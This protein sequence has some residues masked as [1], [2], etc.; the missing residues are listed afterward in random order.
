[1]KD[2]VAT[3]R[4]HLVP[5][6]DS[7][8]LMGHALLEPFHRHFPAEAGLMD[9]WIAA[10]RQALDHIDD[11]ETRMAVQSVKAWLRPQLDSAFDRIQ[12]LNKLPGKPCEFCP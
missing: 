7:T 3:C 2:F 8:R 6:M 5:G 9:K 12:H 1:M 10:D 11:A 4:H